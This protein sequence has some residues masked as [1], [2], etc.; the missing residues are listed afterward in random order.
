[1]TEYEFYDF[2]IN[3]YVNELSDDGYHKD[4]QIY[5][6][7]DNNYAMIILATLGLLGTPNIEKTVIESLNK[8][9]ASVW[10]ETDG[11]F[12]FTIVNGD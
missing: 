9:G 5:G 8:S 3:E 12:T 10:R 11:T 2:V 4:F 7:Y 1:M 6:G